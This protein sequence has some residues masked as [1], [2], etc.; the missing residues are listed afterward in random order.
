MPCRCCGW[1]ARAASPLAIVFGYACHNTTLQDDFVQFHGDYAGVAQ[2]A[3]EARHPGTTALFVAGCGADANPNPR[4]TLELV[5]GARHRIGRRGG[6]H[7]AGDGA[8]RRGPSRTAYET[9]DL[10]FAATQVRGALAQRLDVEDVYL[11]RHAALMAA[12][13]S[14]VTAGCPRRR[15]TRS[16]CGAS[17]RT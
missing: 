16:R 9:V 12:I 7:A 5:A 4:G 17:G 11:R 2:A 14:L 3:L 1:T 6:P 8:G 13:A 10:P 15:P